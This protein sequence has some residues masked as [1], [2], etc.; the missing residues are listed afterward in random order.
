[1]KPL[2]FYRLGLQ[3][4]A[5][6]SSEAQYRTA[7]SRIY[8]GLHHE[9]CCRYYRREL[10]PSPLNRNSRHTELRERFNS[11]GETVPIRIAQ[12]LNDLSVMRSEADYQLTPP[13][14]YK[15]K[16]YSAE[17]LVQEAISTAEYLLRYLERYSP[18]EA[19]DGCDCPTVY[20]VR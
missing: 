12:C 13:L 19:P 6:A 16:T 4:A 18:G 9:A 15:R 14:R 1:M 7:I 11:L 3:I 2:D 20:S 5:S 17:H 10:Y 8:Y